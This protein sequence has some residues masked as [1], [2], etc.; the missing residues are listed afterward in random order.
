MIHILLIHTEKSTH[1]HTVKK[2]RVGYQERESRS[3]KA[4]NREK[5]IKKW[6]EK[7]EANDR[8]SE[9]VRDLVLL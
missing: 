1:T 6:T 3:E 9:L 4:K 7:W 2:S 8:N 5:K